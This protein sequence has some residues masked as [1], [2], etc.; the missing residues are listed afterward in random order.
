MKIE[1]KKFGSL[2]TSRQL[3]KEALAAFEPSLRN[4]SENEEEL[5]DFEGTMTF[6]PSWGDEFLTPLAKRYGERFKLMDSDNSS[7]IAIIET[8]EEAN[9]FKFNRVK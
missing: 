2:L 4:I 6:S 8:L 3:G 9:N 1:I 7:V 5:I